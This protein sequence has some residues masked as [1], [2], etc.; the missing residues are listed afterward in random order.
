MDIAKEMRRLAYL[1]AMGVDS[2]ISRRPLPGAAPTHRLRLAVSA[3][4]VAQPSTKAITGREDLRALVPGQ[5][6]R[7][8]PDTEVTADQILR[9]AQDRAMASSSPAPRFSLTIIIVGGWL[10]IEDLDG[11]PLAKEQLQLVQAMGQSVARLA[12]EPV[13]VP[14]TPQLMSFDWPIHSNSQL[15]TGAEAASASAASFIARQL[16]QHRCRGLVV[17]GARAKARVQLPQPGLE[18]VVFL[19]ASG[20]LLDEP[21]LKQQAWVHLFAAVRSS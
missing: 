8:S 21:E 6:A 5:A 9:S 3:P 18:R 11:Q 14:D 1:E 17:L 4:A 2:Y 13:A 19:P 12:P 15:E 10:W 7:S 16:D 20:E